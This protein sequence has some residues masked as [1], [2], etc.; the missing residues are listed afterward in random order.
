[1][2]EEFDEFPIINK[3]QGYTKGYKL[4]RFGG[5]IA[6]SK[7]LRKWIEASTSSSKLDPTTKTELTKLARDVQRLVNA[8]KITKNE[9]VSEVLTKGF[10]VTS[11]Y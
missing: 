1:M 11:A 10:S 2:I 7:P 9:R 6:I 5:K 4:D 3:E 8:V